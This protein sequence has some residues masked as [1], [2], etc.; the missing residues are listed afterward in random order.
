MAL[1]VIHKFSRETGFITPSQM[2]DIATPSLL[3]KTL[4]MAVDAERH[5][6]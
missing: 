4:L 5:C 1:I 3:Q 2:F 6:P